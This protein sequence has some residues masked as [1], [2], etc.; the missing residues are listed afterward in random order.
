MKVQLTWKDNS[1][2]ETEQRI[3]VS[4]DAQGTD[5]VL[6][7]TVGPNIETAEVEIPSGFRDKRAY[8]TVT[9]YNILGES[10]M[11]SFF[12]TVDIQHDGKYHALTH[13]LAEKAKTVKP[14]LKAT[15]RDLGRYDDKLAC[16]YGW[17]GQLGSGK[18]LSIANGKPY[19][20]DPKTLALSDAPMSTT[21]IYYQSNGKV[22]ADGRYWFFAKVYVD[23]REVS[24]L[25]SSDG[26]TEVVEYIHPTDLP[27]GTFV[28]NDHLGN[29]L[30]IGFTNPKI[31]VT[32]V[33]PFTKQA[34]TETIEAS[35]KSLAHFGYGH[36][37]VVTE[38]GL[39]VN[40]YTVR[41]GGRQV[42]TIYKLNTVGVPTYEEFEITELF[43]A[44]REA[45]LVFGDYLAIFG[46]EWVEGF[47]ASGCLGMFN[48]KTNT[49]ERYKLPSVRDMRTYCMTDHG[50]WLFTLG[51]GQTGPDIILFDPIA[52]SH[53][54]L[55]LGGTAPEGD[56]KRLFRADGKYLMVADQMVGSDKNTVV[57]EF[58][59]EFNDLAIDPRATR[60]SVGVAPIKSV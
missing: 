42:T 1:T 48:V 2:T 36:N 34:T 33:D 23:L 35:G 50:E 56:Y 54:V 9:S 57:F 55:S 12:T 13:L 11:H 46:E 43:A 10:D 19:F 27:E 37:P 41:V 44:S 5:R 29:V 60:T 7:K 6:I 26:E 21:Q 24:A 17:E 14:T 45:G 15:R 31:S 47:Q 22:A 30:L 49:I 20:H 38:E 52:K 39:L 40:V 3:Y 16:S 28:V 32:K 18:I 53:R 8:L 58:E 51:Y 25:V 59:F 4:S